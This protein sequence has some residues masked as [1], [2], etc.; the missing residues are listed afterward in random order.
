MCD[1]DKFFGCKY[2]TK[3]T[4]ND[5][6]YCY[7]YSDNNV[8]PLELFPFEHHV[9]NTGKYKTKACASETTHQTHY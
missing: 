7:K 6:K 3:C 9:E 8:I 2:D 1:L 5:A 4:T